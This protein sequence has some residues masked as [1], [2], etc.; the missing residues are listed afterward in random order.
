[1]LT[2]GSG[3]MHDSDSEAIEDQPQRPLDAEET[4]QRPEVV[5]PV[6]EPEPV[7]ELRV[8]DTAQTQADAAFYR[9][10]LDFWAA[11]EAELA[12][13]V[14]PGLGTAAH[15]LPDIGPPP[16]VQAQAHVNQ[17]ASSGRATEETYPI[18]VAARRWEESRQSNDYVADDHLRLEGELLVQ[19]AAAAFGELRDMQG[20]TQDEPNTT[21]DELRSSSSRMTGAES[22]RRRLDAHASLVAL[23]RA[24]DGAAAETAAIAHR[25]ALLHERKM[26]RVRQFEAKLDVGVKAANAALDAH[27][28]EARREMA[29]IDKH[30]NKVASYLRGTIVEPNEAAYEQN[31]LALDDALRRADAFNERRGAFRAVSLDVDRHA[32]E[33]EAIVT[34]TPSP[35]PPPE[36]REV[37]TQCEATELVDAGSQTATEARVSMAEQATCSSAKSEDVHENSAVIDARSDAVVPLDAQAAGEGWVRTSAWLSKLSM[38]ATTP[39]PTPSAPASESGAPQH[40]ADFHGGAADTNTTHASAEK[41]V[42]DT[43][44][45]GANAMPTQVSTPQSFQVNQQQFDVLK[46]TYRDMLSALRTSHSAELTALKAKHERELSVTMGELARVRDEL[47]RLRDEARNAAEYEVY[48]YRKEHEAELITLREALR[49]NWETIQNESVRAAEDT[50][51]RVMLA[52]TAQPARTAAP[53]DPRTD[54]TDGERATAA[55]EAARAWE[56]SLQRRER[57]AEDEDVE[58]DETI[59]ITPP[60]PQPAIFTPPSRVAPSSAAASTGAATDDTLVRATYTASKAFDAW[61]NRSETAAETAEDTR[62]E[63]SL[64]NALSSPIDGAQ[65]LHAVEQAQPVMSV[66]SAGGLG[67]EGEYLRWKQSIASMELAYNQE[68]ASLRKDSAAALDERDE[69]VRALAADVSALEQRNRQ[70]LERQAHGGA[71]RAEVSHIADTTTADPDVSAN[72][73]RLGNEDLPEQMTTFVLTPPPAPAPASVRRV[74]FADTAPPAAPAARDVPLRIALATREPPHQRLSMMHAKQE[75]RES[76]ALL[77]SLVVHPHPSHYSPLSSSGDERS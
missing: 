2:L 67:D 10:E 23:A 19:A 40:P 62:G 18:G 15:E 27:A 5:E 30:I 31:R 25:K 61:S 65:S 41:E 50:A 43:L 55:A 64:S 28:S 16:N 51:R 14:C 47:N 71:A 58:E 22:R 33:A 49:S 44:N 17:D 37:D 56:E 70:L 35:P 38:R 8:D 77:R 24:K 12:T 42:A 59:R 36:R 57:A 7:E 75:A 32:A 21:R 3:S 13:Y 34:V 68:M 1:M 53:A 73:Q 20:G 76:I 45:G 48:K 29:H 9:N 11:K 72:G 6:V 63:V 69:T 52:S 26:Q 66:S 46:S 39:S 4:P 74:Q 54:P 60:P